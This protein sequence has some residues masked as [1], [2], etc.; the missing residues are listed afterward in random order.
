[1]T[2]TLGCRLLVPVIM[3]RATGCLGSCLL[4]HC[5]QIPKVYRPFVDILQF[6]LEFWIH[7]TFLKRYLYT[8]DIPLFLLV[9]FLPGIFDEFPEQFEFSSP[10]D[11]I[12]LPPHFLE[13]FGS[14]HL[15]RC[16]LIKVS[17]FD[18]RT[19]ACPLSV[20]V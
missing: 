13:L 1:M 19:L 12:G 20:L 14:L 7:F 16:H 10:S 2:M 18:A 8:L 9:F 11:L 15:G 3:T 4:N 17:D 6:W 5:L